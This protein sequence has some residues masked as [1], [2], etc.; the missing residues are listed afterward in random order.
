[1]ADA[2]KSDSAEPNVVRDIDLDIVAN[3]V[4]LRRIIA[5]VADPTPTAVNNYNRVYSRHNR[6]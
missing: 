3:S 6:S 1:M 4:A 2:A 5:E